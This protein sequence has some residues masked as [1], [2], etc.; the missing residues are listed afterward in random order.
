MLDR[1]FKEY[2]L[3][4]LYKASTNEFDPIIVEGN[5]K[6]SFEQTFSA[7]LK[8]VKIEDCCYLNMIPK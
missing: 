4:N 1:L 5:E 7:T 3:D 6:S 8:S 2:D